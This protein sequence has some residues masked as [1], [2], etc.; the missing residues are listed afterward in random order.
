MQIA[1]VL[2]TVEPG[3]EEET[4]AELKQLVNVKEACRVYGVYDIV[5][6][7]EAEDHEKLRAM[8]SKIRHIQRIR[9]TTTLIV[10][11]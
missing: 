8:I 10:W 5:V 2:L 4:L 7:I 3:Y 1:Y 6:R 9:S 11:E